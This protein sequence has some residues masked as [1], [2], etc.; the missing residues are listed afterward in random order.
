MQRKNIKFLATVLTFTFALS[1]QQSAYS[2]D[3]GDSCRVSRVIA[4]PDSY[5]VNVERWWQNTSRYYLPGTTW[6]G[7]LAGNGLVDKKHRNGKRDTFIFV[8][9]SIDF[10][11]EVVLIVWCHGL[12]GFKL[13]KPRLAASIRELISQQRNFILVAPEMPWSTNTSTPRKRQGYVWNGRGEENF[14]VFYN[15]VM[16]KIVGTFHPNPAV[17]QMCKNKQRCESPSAFKSVII[18]HSAGGSA[19]RMAAKTGALEMMRPNLIV[20]SDASYGRWADTTWKYYV[21]K[22]PA[23]RYILLVRKWDTPYRNAQRLLKSVRSRRDKHRIELKVFPRGWTH[24]K[25]GD[26][27]IFMDIVWGAL[28]R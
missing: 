22:N 12:S 24:K 17:R 5:K 27:S 16:R 21:K 25:I 7:P 1:L 6:I 8:P 18:G 19:I 2:Q 28:G 9:H 23:C 10:S 13:H 20:Y 15:S 3:C 14:A 4:S 26:S 11:K